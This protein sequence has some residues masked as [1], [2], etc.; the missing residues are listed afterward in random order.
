MSTLD[1]LIAES[2]ERDLQ[3]IWVHIA[4][5][6]FDAADAQL[7]RVHELAR[8][9][10]HQPEAGTE[11]G[12]GVR[13]FPVGSYVLYYTFDAV[14]VTVRRVVHGRRDFDGNVF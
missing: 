13:A 1:L 6:D 5:H 10:C 9:L 8:L 7:R 14:A 11:R 12:Q 4:E 2:A 3:Q